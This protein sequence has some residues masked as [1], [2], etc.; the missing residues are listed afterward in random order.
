MNDLEITNKDWIKFST[1][2]ARRC[3]L[4]YN[5]GE[6]KKPKNEEADISYVLMVV[7]AA[8]EITN[9]NIGEKNHTANVRLRN[10]NLSVCPI[11]LTVKVIKTLQFELENCVYDLNIYDVD[12]KYVFIW[13]AIKNFVDK[14]TLKKITIYT[15]N[16]KKLTSVE[17]LEKNLNN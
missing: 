12:H 11:K 3:V 7:R 4:D 17:N 10:L 1:D 15:T 5:V 8:V 13:D 6:L 14:D 2:S 16:G 9:K